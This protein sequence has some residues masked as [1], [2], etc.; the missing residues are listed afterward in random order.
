MTA[1]GWGM[2]FENA[3]AW[4][5]ACLAIILITIVIQVLSATDVDLAWLLIVGEKMMDGQ[6]LY[7]DVV[8]VNPPLSVLLYMPA[9]VLGRLVGAP[10]EWVVIPLVILAAISS[11]ALS[12]QIVSPLLG[13]GAGP[14]WRFIAIGLFVLLLFPTGV[15]DERDHIAVIALMPFISLAAVRATGRT[16]PVALATLAGMGA[17][18]AMSIK[19]HF[20]LAAGLPLLINSLSRRSLR[21]ALGIESWVAAAVVV[22]YGALVVVAFP[23]FITDILPPDRDAYIAVRKPLGLFLGAMAIPV[24]LLLVCMGRLLFGGRGLNVTPA[25]PFLAASLGGAGAYLVQGKLWAYQSYPM[26]AFAVLFVLAGPLLVSATDKSARPL[27]PR[28]RWLIGVATV[29]AIGLGMAWFTIKGAPPDGLRERIAQLG[30]NPRMLAITPDIALGP[31]L[32]RELHGAWVASGARQTFS[33]EAVR[34]EA[35]GHLTPSMRA[36]MDALMAAERHSLTHDIL[37]GRPTVIL[38]DRRG[39][40]WGRW[41]RADPDL[42]RA[43][44]AYRPDRT[45]GD[46]DVWVRG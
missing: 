30:A 45:F 23:H 16:Q 13:E 34:L 24:I 27:A 12:A 40:D 41:A 10:P 31:P 25:L 39:F 28:E 17:G 26:W 22:A 21:P 42:A 6:R 7:V 33:G 37:Q 5:I 32:V 44:A 11:V 14:S 38:I 3:R 20:A 8:E 35:E 15:Y 1:I 29:G 18:V 2:G 46:V 9:I 4:K 43:L 36:R 19:P